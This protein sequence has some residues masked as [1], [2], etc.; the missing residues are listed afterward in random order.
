MATWT[1][2]QQQCPLPPVCSVLAAV[3]ALILCLGVVAS[4]T[5]ARRGVA[6]RAGGR[7]VEVL[8]RRASQLGIPHAAVA[9]HAAARDGSG[10]H[11]L[12]A[13]LSQGDLRGFECGGVRG[14]SMGGRGRT[15]G[16]TGRVAAPVLTISSLS[17]S[18]FDEQGTCTAT[19]SRTGAKSSLSLR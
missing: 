12:G 1:L 16:W 6:V 3:P 15:G 17:F 19:V 14:G 4:S 2:N 11:L 5:S 9:G 7:E 8:E 18:F 13:S 10:V